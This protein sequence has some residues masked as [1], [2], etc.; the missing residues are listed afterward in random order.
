MISPYYHDEC[1]AT[2]IQSIE[3]PYIRIP[4]NN[5]VKSLVGD[6]IM[7][8]LWR[9]RTDATVKRATFQNKNWW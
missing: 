5:F 2:I 8:L 3:N 1:D 7:F 6:Q 4:E 9:N